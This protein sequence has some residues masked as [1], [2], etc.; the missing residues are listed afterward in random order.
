LSIS[1]CIL[2]VKVVESTIDA[3]DLGHKTRDNEDDNSSIEC[4]SI[5]MNLRNN[6]YLYIYIYMYVDNMVTCNDSDSKRL[7]VHFNTLHAN[8][9]KI[10]MELA[11]F[12]FIFL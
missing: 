4:L 2:S 10:N 1:V 6:D 11:L 5:L 7:S 8:K 12:P 9:S 3:H